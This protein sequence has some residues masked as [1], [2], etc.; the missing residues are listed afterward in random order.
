MASVGGPLSGIS[1]NFV[2]AA[3]LSKARISG[4]SLSKPVTLTGTS[5]RD[6]NWPAASQLPRCAVSNNTPKTRRAVMKNPMPQRP[7]RIRPVQDQ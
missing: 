1:R 4:N 3:W 6:S 5:R 2:L 7:P